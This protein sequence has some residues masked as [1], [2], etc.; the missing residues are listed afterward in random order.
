MKQLILKSAVVFHAILMSVGIAYAQQNTKDPLNVI[1][2]MVDDLGWRDLGCMGSTYYET[3]MI[4]QFSRESVTFTNAYSNAPN[5]APSRACFLTGLYSPRHGIYTV[6]SSARGPARHR[7]LV[8]TKN[9]TRLS[10]RFLSMA[11]LMKSNGYT[12]ATVGKWHLGRDPGLHGFDVNVGG[13]HTGSPRGGYFSPYRN[14]ELTDGVGNEYLTD[15]LTK[16]AVTFIESHRSSPFFLLL[17]HYAVHTP[18][19]GKA[20]M[21]ARYRNKTA[22]AGHGDPRYAAMIESVDQSFGELVKTL[23]TLQLREKTV[24]I[25]FSD[26]GGYGPV[27]SMRPLRGSKGMLYEGG[28]RVPLIVHWPGNGKRGKT[29]D[30][31]V[32][33]M[34]MMPTLVEILGL[35]VPETC[36]FDGESLAPLLSGTGPL[37]RQA[38]YWHFPA[39]LERYRGM[40][41]YWRTTPAGAIRSGDYKLI[42]FFEEG[43]LELYDL[44]DDPGETRNLATVLPDEVKRLHQQLRIWRDQVDAPVPCEK[45]PK[46]QADSGP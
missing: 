4:D 11:D 17:S 18:I 26:N 34:D 27:T 24:L 44:A 21:I 22:S 8:P 23:T 43:D 33:G 42:E 45:N 30:T 16:E 13:N 32:I 46:Y 28:I 6:G 40:E 15:R 25:F 29:C 5:C 14:P 41:T 9:T 37:E 3:P 2:F 20:D 19:Q 1:V 7:K 36:D 39:Y 31:P 10:R 35:K 12:T 38:L